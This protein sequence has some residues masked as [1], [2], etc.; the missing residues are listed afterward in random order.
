MSIAYVSALISDRFGVSDQLLLV[1]R[2][3]A[4]AVELNLVSY[5]WIVT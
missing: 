1:N 4:F 3:K 2:N 5:L